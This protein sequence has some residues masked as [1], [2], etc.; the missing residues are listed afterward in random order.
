MFFSL[1]SQLI[2]DLPPRRSGREPPFSTPLTRFAYLICVSSVI[3]TFTMRPPNLFDPK[4]TLDSELT[5]L[6]LPPTSSSKLTQMKRK[7]DP[8]P[9]GVYYRES[10]PFFRFLL[11]I[12]LSREEHLLSPSVTLLAKVRFRSD[13]KL[14]FAISQSAL[15]FSM[16]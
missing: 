4:C 15:T 13:Q 5:P 12:F 3:P 7:L 11:S 6:P 8:H 14:G 2:P 16:V 10:L 1:T 9:K